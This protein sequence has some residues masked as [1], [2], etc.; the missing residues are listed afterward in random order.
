MAVGSAL[1]G[2]L[3]GMLC[4][5]AI[6]T[7]AQN[8]PGI[9]YKKLDARSGDTMGVVHALLML[10]M[11]AVAVSTAGELGMLSLDGNYAYLI[12]AGLALVTALLLTYRGMRPLS[13]RSGS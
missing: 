4:H 2:V 3:M 5:F 10:M 7:G 9:Y 8:L 1:F 11:G 6:E 12:S 13:R